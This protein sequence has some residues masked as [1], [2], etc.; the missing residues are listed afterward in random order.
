MVEV[1]EY[2]RDNSKDHLFALNG[3]NEI[4]FPV[5]K[6]ILVDFLNGN[7]NEK[8][9]EKNRLF[10]CKNFGS[11]NYLGREKTGDLIEKLLENGLITESLSILDKSKKLLAIS[12]KGK[13][14]ISKNSKGSEEKIS[15]DGEFNE[16]DLKFLKELQKFLHGF[17]IEQKKAVLSGN[18]RV[19]C[20]A[21][22]GS[23]KT[24]VLTKKIEFL[25]KFRR[26]NGDE[27][28]AITFTRKAR[29]EME[30]RLKEAGVKVV[31]ETF[32]SFSEKILLKYGGKIY[33]KKVRVAGIQERMVSVLRAL[34]SLDLTIKEAIEK[35]FQNGLSTRKN[36]YELQNSFISDCFIVLE[37]FKLSNTPIDE[38]RKKYFN[39]GDEASNMVFEIIKFVDKYFS[40]FGFR[41]YADQINDAINFFRMHPKFIP[42]FSHILVDEFQDVN[43][44][45]I[46]FLDILNP[47]NLFA[48]GDPRQSIYGWRGSKIEYIMEFREK[49]PDSEV[50]SMKKNYRS[51]KSV[52]NL[53]NESVKHMNLPD[54]EST[55]PEDTKIEL[56]SF[57][58]EKEE[59]DFIKDKI[60]SS[61]IP[62]EEIF[63]LGR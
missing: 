43:P 20:I 42:H 48:V 31:V 3:L 9:V 32:N 27:I 38:F 1:K 46:D 15:E 28:L 18:K 12:E 51:S 40:N 49:Y 35:Y 62:R 33:G 23:G 4:P 45:Q 24:T 7:E 22:A 53:I 6:K 56:L 5:E 19:L 54:L 29:E 41:T 17:N 2:Q 39:Y 11:M 61:V 44:A 34:D 10:L 47:E 21:G 58:S 13:T 30:R 57:K 26:I 63:V 37:Y 55:F 60:S 25:A 8:V 14:E 50:I 52:V 36:F 16:K 59:F